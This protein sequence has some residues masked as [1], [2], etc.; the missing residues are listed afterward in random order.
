[1]AHARTQIRQALVTRLSGLTTTDNRVE[2]NRIYE[3]QDASLPALNIIVDAEDVERDTM[4]GILRRSATIVVEGYAR[5][6]DNIDDVLDQIATEVEIAIAG[7]PLLGALLSDPMD[8]VGI[9]IDL[10]AEA[11]SPAGRISMQ[12]AAAYRTARTDPETPL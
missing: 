10:D 4:G 9:D 12:Y 11:K 5:A 3:V 2:A 8:V 6:S 7:D 1:M